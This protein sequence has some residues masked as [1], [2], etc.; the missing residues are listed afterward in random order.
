MKG[1]QVLRTDGVFADTPLNTPDPSQ[2]GEEENT[3]SSYASTPL[4]EGNS[5]RD[6]DREVNKGIY[7]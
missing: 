6:E 7:L 1:W 2:R 5:E 3:P 4:Q